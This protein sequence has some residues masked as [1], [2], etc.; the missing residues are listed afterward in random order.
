M[1]RG[2]TVAFRRVSIGLEWNTR[3]RPRPLPTK[4]LRFPNKKPAGLRIP[5]QAG[6]AWLLLVRSR[7]LR[8]VVR[9]TLFEDRHKVTPGLWY[10]NVLAS[11]DF[12]GFD[13]MSVDTFTGVVIRT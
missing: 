6:L 3:C 7:V 1:T 12:L 2:E 8:F 4:L 5:R 13:R 9:R 10:A 11:Y